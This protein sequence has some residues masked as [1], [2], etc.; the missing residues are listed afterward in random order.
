[1][2]LTDNWQMAQVQLTTDI[3]TPL[4]SIPAY[5]KI[6]DSKTVYN[7]VN[8]VAFPRARIEVDSVILQTSGLIRSWWSS[9]G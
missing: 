7:L 8:K 9:A 5:G 4:P 6:E 2:G 1:M 3:C